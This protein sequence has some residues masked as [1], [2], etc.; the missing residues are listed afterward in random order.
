MS[1]ATFSSHVTGLSPSHTLL[2]LA[3][4]FSRVHGDSGWLRRFACVSGL[5]INL[6]GGSLTDG[7]DTFIDAV[8]LCIG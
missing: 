7:L 2:V 1:W 4:S 3:N 8:C 5:L 6:L